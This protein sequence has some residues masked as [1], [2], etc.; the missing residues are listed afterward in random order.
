LTTLELLSPVGDFDC[1]K[2]AVQNGA[3]AVYLGASNFNARASASNFNLEELEKAVLYAKLRNVKV[4][5]T[6]NT[7]INN[8]EINEAISL[9]TSAYNLG[10]DGVIIQDLGLASILHENLPDLPLHA[11]TQ[12]TTYNLSGVKELETLGFKRVVLARELSIPEIEYICNNTNLEIEVFV[13]GALCVSYSGQC[14]MSSSI[15]RKK[16]KSWQMCSALQIAIYITKK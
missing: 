12:M 3:N 1:L 5:L 14:L 13:H 15:G 7:L 8:D 4:Y 10:I 2:A 6:L 11:S 9:A 16:R